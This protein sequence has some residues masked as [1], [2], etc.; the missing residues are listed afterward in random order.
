[1]VTKIA[2][3][4][5]LDP[6]I[7]AT[8]GGLT[9]PAGTDVPDRETL[10]ARAN[11]EEAKARS[12]MIEGLLDQMDDEAVASSKGLT[13]R[14]ESLVS[15]PDGNTI[16]LHFIRP[17]NSEIVPCV[18][19]IHGGGMAYLSAER[20]F[21][22]AWGR[23]IAAQGVAVAMIDFRNC[24]TAS[25]VPE[26]APYPAGLNDCVSGL[27]WVHANA[28]TLGIDPT[29][30]I[31]AGESGGG[32]LT[33]AA[34]MKLKRD[35][36][37]GLI[38]GLYALCPY[39]AGHWPAPNSPSSV[40]N[41]GILLDLHNNNGAIGYGIEAFNAR[42][43]LAWPGFAVESDVQGLPNVVISVNECDPLRDEGVNFYRLLL[44]AGVP[45]RCRQMMGTIHATEVFP[46]VCPDISR[47]TARDMAAFCKG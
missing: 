14:W 27:K 41:N 42:D 40:E 12:A 47:D 33:L 37:I 8:F 44:R 26:V 13:S 46:G 36:N 7:K 21:F 3:D 6:R 5:R 38:N 39:I 11:S 28:T 1:V 29:R 34:G 2:A 32:N 10:L 17:D 22:K 20:G 19:Y 23:V 15:A 24:V 25:S 35:G 18:Y 30:I 31:I 16:R 45:A 4:P 9:L 43:P